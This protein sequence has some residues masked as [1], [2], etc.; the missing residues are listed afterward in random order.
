MSNTARPGET[1]GV[2]KNENENTITP[3]SSRE[4]GG[5]SWTRVCVRVREGERVRGCEGFVRNGGVVYCV[6][7]CVVLCV[8]G[9]VF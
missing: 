8:M 5:A 6:L 3:C 9:G 4:K 1:D 2:M 7:Y